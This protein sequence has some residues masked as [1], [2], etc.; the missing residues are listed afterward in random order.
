MQEEDGDSRQTNLWPVVVTDEPS[1]RKRDLSE[2][3]ETFW[4]AYPRRV[5]KAPA[6]V[7]LERALQNTTLDAILSG[8][9]AY[10]RNKPEYQDWMHPASWLNAERW[11]DEW[12]AEQQMSP[13]QIQY[14]QDKLNAD[15]RLVPDSIRQ[16]LPQKLRIVENG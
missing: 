8:I 3:F 14:W 12:E 7:A 4:K 1:F 11:D 2:A 9:Q 16:Q 13:D 15:P 10:K 5:S 6:R